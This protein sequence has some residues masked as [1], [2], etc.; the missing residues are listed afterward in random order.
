MKT[1]LM[2]ILLVSTPAFAAP[3]A[4]LSKNNS[5]CYGREYTEAHM[6]K[7]PL[8]TVKTMKVRID[9]P[10]EELNSGLL[11]YIDLK[12][13]RTTTDGFDFLKPYHSGMFCNQEGNN[14]FC[15]IECDGGSAVVSWSVKDNGKTI[16]FRNNGFVVYGGCGED[17]EES[18][19]LEA[20]KGGDDVFVLYK[21]PQEYCAK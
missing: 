19:Y 21:L 1:F 16:T 15:G 5:L 10:D 6:A 20:A 3:W 17:V 11:M 12:L 13:K 9:A 4:G 7:H 18:E 14:L 8:Q 2:L